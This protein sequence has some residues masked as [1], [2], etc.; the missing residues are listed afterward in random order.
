MAGIPYQVAQQAATAI[1]ASVTSTSAA[2]PSAFMTIDKQRQ[3]LSIVS[4][5]NQPTIVLRN[6][7]YWHY[8]AA[9]STTPLAAIWDIGANGGYLG[10]GDSF[11]LYAV[12]ATPTSGTIYGMAV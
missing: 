12:S 10:V 3:L 5:L 2:S 9:F 4:T 6:G 11:T 1:A 7:V 8:L